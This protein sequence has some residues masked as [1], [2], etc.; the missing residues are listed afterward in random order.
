M[1]TMGD[2]LEKVGE[3]GSHEIT[4]EE[5]K[6]LFGWNIEDIS[7]KKLEDNGSLV[8]IAFDNKMVLFIHY[9]LNFDPTESEDNCEYTLALRTDW[10]SRV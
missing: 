5:A 7:A 2:L 10:R 3:L 8:M 1:E 9:F 6:K 4:K